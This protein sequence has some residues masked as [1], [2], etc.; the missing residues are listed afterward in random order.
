MRRVLTSIE[1][2]LDRAPRPMTILRAGLT[3]V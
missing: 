3:R 1:A 2:S